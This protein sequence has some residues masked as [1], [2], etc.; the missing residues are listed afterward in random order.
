MLNFTSIMV[1]PLAEL[2]AMQSNFCS[3]VAKQM[4]GRKFKMELNDYTIYS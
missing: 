3:H 4:Y 2:K 1:S